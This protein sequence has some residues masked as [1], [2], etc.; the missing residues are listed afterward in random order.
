M[1]IWI[2][3]G[4]PH[5]SRPSGELWGVYWED[6]GDNWSRYNGTVLYDEFHS[7]LRNRWSSWVV[8]SVSSRSDSWMST[9]LLTMHLAVADSMF[10]PSQ[11]ETALLCNDVSHWLGAS[12]E[13][14]LQLHQENIAVWNHSAI[15][16]IL[17]LVPAQ[18]LCRCR[19]RLRF[20][21]LSHP[22]KL[23]TLNMG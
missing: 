6:L 15:V 18:T 1:I 22:Q 19:W 23:S 8:C 21:N 4:T 3:Q 12:I 20:N 7:R 2:H 10:A 13:S 17:L 9:T 16:G 14:A 11:W 5:M